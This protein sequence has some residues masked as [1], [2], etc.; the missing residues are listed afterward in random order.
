MHEKM[1]AVLYH[2]PACGTSRNVLALLKERGIAPRIVEYLHTP[3]TR[4]DYEALVA[5]GISVS[6]LLR[7]KEPLYS[8]LDLDSASDEARLDALTLH[9]RLLNRPLLATPKGVRACRPAETALEIL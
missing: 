1:E 5:R 3:P 9:P 2:N 7:S 4:A 8:E 6:T